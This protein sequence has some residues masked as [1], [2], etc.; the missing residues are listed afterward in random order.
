[1]SPNAPVQIPSSIFAFFACKKK[2]LLQKAISSFS[3]NSV[4]SKMFLFHQLIPVAP[5]SPS[6]SL[7]SY[8]IGLD[9]LPSFHPKYSLLKA[10]SE[11]PCQTLTSFLR[12]KSSYLVVRNGTTGLYIV[13][14]GSGDQ[15]TS[16]NPAV[17][18]PSFRNLV[19]P[20]FKLI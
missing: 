18:E 1:M 8:H 19:P 7:T 6:L 16:T 15:R 3:V 9:F 13:R 2:S 5:E 10:H 4:P 14:K 17:S 20:I 11:M 12:K